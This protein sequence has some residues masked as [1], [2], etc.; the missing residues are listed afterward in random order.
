MMKSQNT[1]AS[2][3]RRTATGNQQ[4]KGHLPFG[5]AVERPDTYPKTF[6]SGL[7]SSGGDLHVETTEHPVPVILRISDQ[8]QQRT[9]AWRDETN[10]NKSYP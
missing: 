2:H 7:G 1:R 8:Q 6:M 9:F 10:T 4:G 5:T 3:R